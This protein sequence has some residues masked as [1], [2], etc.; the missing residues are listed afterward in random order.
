[1]TL[2]TR[3][4]LAALLLPVLSAAC[5]ALTT[6]DPSSRAGGS[7]A[8]LVAGTDLRD[9][10]GVVHCHGRLSHDSSGTEAEIVAAS[11]ACGLNFVVMTDHQTD[12]SVRDG[13]RGERDGVLFLVGAEVRTPQG[14]LLAFPLQRP[15]RRW[16][17]FALLAREAAAM[18]AVTFVCHAELWRVPWATAELDGVE[19]VNLHAGAMASSYVG[20]LATGLLLPLRSLMARFCV[21]SRGVFDEWDRA[22]T[23]GRRFV[24]IGGNDAHASVRVFGPLGG[25][26][27]TYREVFA[28]LST[29]V[30]AARRTESDLV[31]G[32]RRGRTYVSFDLFGE[33]TGF[34]FR[35]ERHGECVLGGGEVTAG[36]GTRLR[37]RLP[38]AAHI[39]LLRDGRDV[40]AVDGAEL[41]V[42][43]PVAGTYRVEVTTPG[44]EPW[45]FSS[46]IRVL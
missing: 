22:L 38:H 43:A 25:T 9:W 33:G 6:F 21:R 42:E 5:A 17:H 14:T 19:I 16:Q 23:T 46:A 37:V 24:P 40:A 27:G 12:A 26:I 1:M 39:L 31:D 34:D 41:V 15:L 2:P 10:K 35:G 29:H 28:T 36:S 13:I 3:P 32:I 4:S 11:V 20:T 18:G 8:P 7:E 44:G 30:L 45:L